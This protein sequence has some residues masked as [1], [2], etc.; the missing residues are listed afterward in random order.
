MLTE[1]LEVENSGSLLHFIISSF[2]LCDMAQISSGLSDLGMSLD[3]KPTL[4]L[5]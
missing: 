5:V 1:F 3:L 4:A 2:K